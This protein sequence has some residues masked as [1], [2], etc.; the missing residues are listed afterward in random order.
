MTSRRRTRLPKPK[1]GIIPFIMKM[2]NGEWTVKKAPD[3]R[4]WFTMET[5]TLLTLARVL[6]VG[7]CRRGRGRPGS[8][9]LRDF[10]IYR[11]VTYART[12]AA[13]RMYTPRGGV[14]KTRTPLEDVEPVQLSWDKAHELAQH[15]LKEDWGINLSTGAIRAAYRHGGR[16]ADLIEKRRAELS[17]NQ[18][19]KSPRQAPQKA[20]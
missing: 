18:P 10:V 19:K 1:R 9:P 8:D 20:R 6:G 5:G 4:D 17:M 15:Y 7:P 13:P 11:E 2:P 14:P 3:E 12:R 16:V